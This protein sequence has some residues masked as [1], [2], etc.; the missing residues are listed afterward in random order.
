MYF[1]VPTETF[2][3]SMDLNSKPVCFLNSAAATPLDF[4]SGSVT[5]SEK[6]FVW[7]ASFFTMSSSP[8]L[9]RINVR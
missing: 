3:T 7:P 2:S 6:M 8:R 9:K 5:P 4:L 1:A